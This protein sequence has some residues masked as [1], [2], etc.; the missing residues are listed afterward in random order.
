MQRINQLFFIF[1]TLLPITV[2]SNFNDFG[3]EAF[4]AGLFEQAILN[5]EKALKQFDSNNQNAQYIDTAVYLSIAYQTLGLSEQALYILEN[6]KSRAENINDQIRQANISSHLGDIYIAIA[7]WGKAG[8][9]LK[10]AEN[11]ANQIGSS[12]LLANV[13]NK[14]GN[15]WMARGDLKDAFKGKLTNYQKCLPPE[16]CRVDKAT[17]YPP[18]QS[19]N[20]HKQFFLI[21]EKYKRTK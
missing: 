7:E 14:Q 4:K 17:A 9:S 2:Y 20:P 8:T 5:W 21:N 16:N 19:I 12:L 1:I 10:Q 11:L 6:V 18:K 13:L 3:H 15:L